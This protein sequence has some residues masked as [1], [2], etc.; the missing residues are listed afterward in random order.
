MLNRNKNVNGGA[1]ISFRV[2]ALEELSLLLD[3]DISIT[4]FD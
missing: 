2:I 3:D 1:F 4:I